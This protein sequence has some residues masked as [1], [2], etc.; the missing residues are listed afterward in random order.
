MIISG[1]N[2]YRQEFGSHILLIVGVS[3]KGKNL[4]HSAPS[5]SIF[6]PLRVSTL[7]HLLQ[8]VS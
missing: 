8:P 4:L 5:G 7:K 6:L 3:L 1:D 2:F